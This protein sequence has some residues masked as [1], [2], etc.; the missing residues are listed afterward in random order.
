MNPSPR[1]ILLFYEDSTRG[2]KPFFHKWGFKINVANLY[3]SDCTVAVILKLRLLNEQVC[4]GWGGMSWR[5]ETIRVSKFLSGGRGTAVG[6]VGG[7]LHW[8]ELPRG[9]GHS[10]PPLVPVRT[11]TLPQHLQTPLGAPDESGW[12]GV[13]KFCMIGF[14]NTEKKTSYILSCM[15]PTILPQ[16]FNYYFESL[17]FLGFLYSLYKCMFL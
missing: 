17:N 14:L 4:L 7:V 1:Y 8:V 6:T 15:T 2:K 10:T 11:Q 5:T 13:L 12:Q 9:A 3:N 16:S